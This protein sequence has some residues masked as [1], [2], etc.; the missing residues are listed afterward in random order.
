LFFYFKGKEGYPTLSF[1]VCVDHC[2]RAL[3]VSRFFFGAANDKLIAKND[4]FSLGIINGTLSDVQYLMYNDHGDKIKVR[5]AYLIT[6]G[7]YIDMAC[8]VDPDHHRM[9]R[10]AI[11]WSE[12]LESVRKDVECQYI[13]LFVYFIDLYFI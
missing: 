11:L 8:F 6:D 5:G 3:S 7:G 2:R 12:W 1:Q 4:P 13:A 10:Q 9:T